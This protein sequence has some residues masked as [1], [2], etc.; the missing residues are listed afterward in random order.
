MA[1][2]ASRAPTSHHPPTQGGAGGAVRHTPGA[3]PRSPHLQRYVDWALLAVVLI[4]LAIR[5]TYG[6][7]P[8]TDTIDP[9]QP[10]TNTGFSVLLSGVL[11][12]AVMAGFVIRVLDA[13]RAF[14]PTGLGIGLAF[15]LVAAIVSCF[16]ASDKRAAVTDALTLATPMLAAMLL[17]RLLDRPARIRCVLAIVV[18]GGLVNVL[19]SAQQAMASNRMLIEQY[20]KD[21]QAFLEPLGIERG[22]FK[23]LLYE[24]RLYGK[25]VRGFFTTGNSA[26]SFLILSVAALAAL[27]LGRPRG[28]P[29]ARAWMHAVFVF[30]MIRLVAGM[31][32]VHSK[33]ATVAA[34]AG[35]FLF[36]IGVRFG[37]W[38]RRHRVAV[39]AGG[40]LGVLALAA[41]LT[42]YGRRH[43]T[44]PGGRSMLIRWEYWTATARMVQDHPL[45]GVG[46]GNFRHYYPRYKADAA[47]ETVQ[48]PHN[49]VLSLLSQYGP[50]G[51]LGFVLAI[52]VPAWRAAGRE[53]GLAV[54]DRE[55]GRGAA[56]R[57]AAVALA[58][59]GV[60]FAA[61]PFFLMGQATQQAE[62]QSVTVLY[63]YILPAAVLAA[64]AVL[65][66][67]PFGRLA[68]V[69]AGAFVF[70]ELI[71]SVLFDFDQVRPATVMVGAA[72]LYAV[73][74][75]LLGVCWWRGSAGHG[76]AVKPA[77]YT[78]RWVLWCG[79][80]TVLLAGLVDFALF[81]PGVYTA[82]WVVLACAVASG[83]PRSRDT[84]SAFAWT[85]G[86]RM[87]KALA[88]LLIVATIAVVYVAVVLPVQA[89]YLRQ[90]VSRGREAP[91][92]LNRAASVDPLDPSALRDA[93][94][95]Y[96]WRYEQT[97]ESSWLAP[98]VKTLEEA[99]RRNPASFKDDALMARTYRFLAQSDEHPDA[100]P[101]LALR[102]A[103]Q[104]VRKYPGSAELH[105]DLAEI[106]EA[107]GRASLAL[108]HYKR[109][110]EIERAFQEHFRRM[111]PGRPV[112]SRLGA[113]RYELAQR[114][115]RQLGNE[116][117]SGPTPPGS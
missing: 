93:A 25:D 23:A 76:D 8:H 89:G 107:L 24:H 31:V 96:L 3:M 98:A 60:V 90:Q 53:H 99:L 75:F 35:L 29:G 97:G 112:V 64:G 117:S 116:S 78:W 72:L 37:P 82:F 19:Q 86:P 2:A 51:L 113:E 4:I 18:A 79:L 85:P 45:T 87:R 111:Y 61:R 62:V 5:A 47:L 105:M 38:L 32:M 1:R 74:L 115:V 49:F 68:V 7:S 73:P 34:G 21:P 52:A 10:L 66:L 12:V 9:L 83:A 54:G 92:V 42:V 15:F 69:A 11:L 50:L 70:C 94:K 43:D 46:G 57:S 59:A 36:L 56:F 44:L 84:T 48:D 103:E 26:G 108:E 110:V 58:V 39:A 77:S 91:A 109:A 67:V 6:E 13:G 100:Y 63:L 104:A 17:V 106:A 55:N 40:L 71:E 114:K 14:R 101:E 81:E 27:W 20:E 30:C 33:G 22:T 80:A 16:A 95:L 41:A 28:A 65:L 102:Y 88:G